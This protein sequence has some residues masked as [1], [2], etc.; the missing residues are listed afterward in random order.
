[1]EN[2]A[3]NYTPAFGTCESFG[4]VYT[5]CISVYD[6]SYFSVLKFKDL[7]KEDGKLT[8][9]FKLATDTKP[10]VSH[11]HML[12]FPFVVPKATAHVDKKVLNMRHQVKNGF[13]G[14][15]VGI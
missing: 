4:S 2:V 8:K 15:F 13:C 14:I 12:F 3:Y 7:I 5:F 6:K 1:M 9:S 10:S 11:L